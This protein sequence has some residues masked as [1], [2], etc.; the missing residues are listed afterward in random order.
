MENKDLLTL[1][2]S[3]AALL[4]SSLM[5]ILRR[6]E[7]QRTFRSQFV[8]VLSKLSSLGYEIDSI[9]TNAAA[10]QSGD[11]AALEPSRRLWL[12]HNSL[13]EQAEYLLRQMPA[14]A[15][16]VD[17]RMMA[18]SL[19]SIGNYY[20]ADYYWQ[21]A[22]DSVSKDTT[23]RLG[24]WWRRLFKKPDWYA[25]MLEGMLRLQYADFL[26]LSNEYGA[27][28]EQFKRAIGL[29]DEDHDQTLWEAG[30]ALILL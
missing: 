27:C 14:L 11:L 30:W 2:I 10:Y 3:I 22:L 21:K 19:S 7:L 18:E 28:R 6:H 17:Y 20:R 12:Q 23:S 29:F 5:L 8:D 9:K 26:H 16:H 25:K 15:N 24:A 13:L 4:I 1:S